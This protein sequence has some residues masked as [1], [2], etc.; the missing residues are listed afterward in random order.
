MLRV[1][2]KG[3]TLTNLTPQIRLRRITGITS[4]EISISIKEV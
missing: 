1:I 4:N 3:L 2:E